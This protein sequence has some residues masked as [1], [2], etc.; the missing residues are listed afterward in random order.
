[1]PQITFKVNLATE[2]KSKNNKNFMSSTAEM[3][4]Q[5]SYQAVTMPSINMI[6]Q[7]GDRGD[8]INLDELQEY[9]GGGGSRY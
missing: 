7:N 6:N 3:I 2:Y 8:E 1:M 5:S 9:I 4:P